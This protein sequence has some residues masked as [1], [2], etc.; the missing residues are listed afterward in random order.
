K[1]GITTWENPDNYGL[2]LTL[3]G[4]EVKLIDL[5]R[6]YATLANYG[7]KSELT[8]VIEIKN[9]DNEKFE[10]KSHKTQQVVDPRVAFILTDI[11]KDN[12]ARSPA[13]GTNSLLVI[14]DH[15]AVAVKT[16]TSNNLR[17]N[18]AIGYNQN[19]VVAV[20]VGN[21]DNSQM[22]RIASGITGAT[23]IFNKIMS[24]L[25][26]KEEQSQEWEMP[27]GLVQLPICPYTGTLACT[28]CPIQMEWFLEENKPEK[29]CSPEWFERE[30]VGQV[31]Q[32]EQVEQENQGEILPEAARMEVVDL[33]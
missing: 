19:Y 3:G 4:G 30:K 18:L 1:M 16:G 22:A 8:S 2:S 11:L 27:E 32:V 17:D 14:P 5:A 6:T 13:F 33:R 21:N 10:E 9:L 29:A 26:A 25:L 15:P 24:S 28:G 12:V 23:P 31:N 7:E 20:W